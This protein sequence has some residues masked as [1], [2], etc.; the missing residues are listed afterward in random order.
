MFSLGLHLELGLLILLV[1][2][3]VGFVF[4]IALLLLEFVRFS[5]SIEFLLSIGI[6]FGFMEERSWKRLCWRLS[7]G[8][9]SFSL[10][11]KQIEYECLPSHHIIGIL[12]TGKLYINFSFIDWKSLPI[13]YTTNFCFSILNRESSI[14]IYFQESLLDLNLSNLRF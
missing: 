14:K 6:G 9:K 13:H 8:N 3:V 5:F 4:M 2:V 1:M 12:N 11:K 10:Q 7:F